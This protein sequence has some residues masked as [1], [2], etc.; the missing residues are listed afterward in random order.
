MFGDLNHQYFWIYLEAHFPPNTVGTSGEYP[1]S[2]IDISRRRN[3]KCIDRFIRMIP[4]RRF[5]TRRNCRHRRSRRRRRQHRTKTRS[6]RSWRRSCTAILTTIFIRVWRSNHSRY[7]RNRRRCCS[8]RS[9][10]HQ[11]RQ[12]G[13][14]AKSC[15]SY[16]CTAILTTKILYF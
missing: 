14:L 5:F 13:R 16:P 12:K 4:V 7:R 6:T 3:S 8:R 11:R 2:T 10:C 1:I 9:S 15:R